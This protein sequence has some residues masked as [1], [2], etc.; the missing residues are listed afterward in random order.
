MDGGTVRALVPVG[1]V[2]CHGS[3]GRLGHPVLHG[4]GCCSLDERARPRARFWLLAGLVVGTASLVKPTYLALM[5]VVC[6]PLV[7]PESRRLLGGTAVRQFAAFVLGFSLPVVFCVAWFFKADALNAFAEVYVNYALQVYVGSGFALADRLKGVAMYIQTSP[8]ASLLF[9]TS[10]L[11]SGILWIR[12]RP[13][14]LCLWS[15]FCSVALGLV[16]V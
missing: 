9:A 8:L 6:A 16:V 4:S 7:L 10:V 11:G 1:H 14:T 13:L 2:L 15:W 12:Q 3:T 5:F